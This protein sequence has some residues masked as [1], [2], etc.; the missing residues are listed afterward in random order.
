[1]ISLKILKLKWARVRFRLH[2]ADSRT[3]AS[4]KLIYLLPTALAVAPLIALACAGLSLVDSLTRLYK[5]AVAI[6]GGQ[7]YR[8]KP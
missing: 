2:P 4:L 8:P 3:V 1:M 5:M 7:Q 6:W